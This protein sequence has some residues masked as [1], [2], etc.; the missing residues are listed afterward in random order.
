MTPLGLHH[1]MYS[2]HH[3]G[4]GPWYSSGRRDWTSVYYHRADSLGIGF[5]RTN[6]GSSAVN[7]YFPEV[8]D[9]FNKPETCPENLLLWFNHLPWSYK[10]KS[11]NILWDE[12]CF[13]Y[14]E[15]VKSVGWLRKEWKSLS[16]VIDRD[17]FEAVDKLLAMQERD[18]QIW[19]DGCLLYFQTFSRR[20]FPPGIVPP[21]K[22]LDF[23]KKH[24]YTDIPGISRG[25]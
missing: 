24:I 8:R 19:K 14:D 9:L 10:M 16:G 12:L 6:T 25:L 18:A 4:P 23:Y 3:Y 20:P 11:G 15:G 2:G 7:Q 5:D 22:D 13:K 21:A 1:I 17:R